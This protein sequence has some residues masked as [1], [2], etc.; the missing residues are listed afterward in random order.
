MA[1]K[2]LF[3]ET[4]PA[5]GG[6][7]RS[8]LELAIAL[9]KHDIEPSVAVPPGTLAD[10]LN[11]EKIPVHFLPTSIHSKKKS[12]NHEWT[13]RNTNLFCVFFVFIRVH[14][15]FKTILAL[16]RLLK[17]IQ[18]DILHANSIH[19]GIVCSF[20]KTRHILHVRDLRFNTLLL[21]FAARRAN[22]IA[23]I[24]E[25]VQQRLAAL[26]INSTLIPN[27]INNA[28]FSLQPS[29][30]NLTIGMVA[31]WARWKRHDIFLRMAP[32]LREKIPNARFVL[33]PGEGGS[34]QK[35][36]SSMRQLARENGVEILPFTTDMPRFYATLA[37]LV[38]TAAD[39][40]FGR[41]IYEALAT[42][43]PVVTR[44]NCN[45]PPPCV[46]VD[47]DDPQAFASASAQLLRQRTPENVVAWQ[48][49]CHNAAAAFDINVTAEK[50]MAL[51]VDVAPGAPWRQPGLR[52]STT[53]ALLH[54]WLTQA[55]LVPGAPGS[56]LMRSKRASSC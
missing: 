10:A 23:A 33:L 2:V 44:Q 34:D 37:C 38:H 43:V 39:E 9:Q 20:Q 29:A 45:L 30:F 47:S 55:G 3:V 53:R 25:P 12:K 18:P 7:Q 52:E 21:R 36:E 16:R 51:Y 8:L 56:F 49:A 35:H 28:R 46:L 24:S 31:Q 19:A 5:L 11:A 41:V 1:I 15:W 32:L 50:C 13:R 17:K 48:T 14:S 6:A 26:K 54:N 40:P 42:G 4:N 27:G 22:A